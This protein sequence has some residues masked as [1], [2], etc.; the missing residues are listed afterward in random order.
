MRLSECFRLCTCLFQLRSRTELLITAW[1]KRSL[2]STS[3]GLGANWWNWPN[4]RQGA[5]PSLSAWLSPGHGGQLHEPREPGCKATAAKR[6]GSTGAHNSAQCPGRRPG[7]HEVLSSIESACCTYNSCTCG[8][9]SLFASMR[10]WRSG[11]RSMH[12]RRS[13]TEGRVLS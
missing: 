5:W 4:A 10:R 7:S 9:W 2:L 8:S 13:R 12:G 3:V 6:G 1:S 11:E